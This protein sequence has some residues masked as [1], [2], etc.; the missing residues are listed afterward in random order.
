[1]AGQPLAIITQNQHL[2]LRAE[3]PEREFKELNKIKCAKFR[4]SYS[5][6][7]YD[8]KSMGGELFVMDD[9]WFGEKYPRKTDNSALGDWKVDR[10]K[11]PNGIEGL[12]DEAKKLGV[13][14]GIWIEPEMSNT[15][16]ELYD[17]HPD[18]VIKAPKASASAPTQSVWLHAT[19][20]S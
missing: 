20:C 15:K 19:I 3:I 11:L 7:L 1:M 14:F 18:W 17:K 5:D 4:T 13:K 10:E 8:I 6:R 9:G 16:S 12:L 2:Y